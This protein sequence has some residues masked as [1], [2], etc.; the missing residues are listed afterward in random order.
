MMTSNIS[1]KTRQLYFDTVYDTFE[2][3][4]FTP[5]YHYGKI[6]N[7]TSTQMRAAYPRL[8][9]FLRVRTKIDPNG[10]F[11]NDFIVQLLGL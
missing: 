3:L 4:G 9:D 10:I 8:D 7:I 1:S 5:R 6:F 2:E 11:L